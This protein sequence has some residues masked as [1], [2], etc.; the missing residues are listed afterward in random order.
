MWEKVDVSKHISDIRTLGE[1]NE[2]HLDKVLLE[3]LITL[4]PR[5]HDFENLGL[6]FTCHTCLSVYF[7]PLYTSFECKTSKVHGLIY[8]GVSM[9]FTRV[10]YDVLH[11]GHVKGA[12]RSC[13]DYVDFLII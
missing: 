2:L 11:D 10:C 5:S 13:S 9:Y 3:H 7:C 6:Q 1:V 12:H 4:L 8:I